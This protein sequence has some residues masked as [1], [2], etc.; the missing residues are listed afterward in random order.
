M[1]IDAPTEDRL[2]AQGS[3]DQ[4]GPGGDGDEDEPFGLHLF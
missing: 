1:K 2:V 4:L 3:Q